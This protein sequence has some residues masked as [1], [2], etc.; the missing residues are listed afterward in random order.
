MV[1][2]SVLVMSRAPIA[3]PVEIRAGNRRVYRLAHDIGED[4]LSLEQPAPF[5]EGRP[6][7]IRFVLPLPDE[8]V[9]LTLKAELQAGSHAA[10]D[11]DGRPLET[12]GGSELSFH[13]MSP[14]DL[15]ELRRYIK[16]RLTRP[17]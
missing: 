14:N 4:G 2:S 5:D 15:E 6:V 17:V 16:G 3:V 7:E 10:V 9:A 1:L 8:T 12:F 13:E 11:E